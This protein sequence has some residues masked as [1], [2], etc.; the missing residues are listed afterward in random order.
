MTNRVKAFL[1]AVVII[2]TVSAP[3]FPS[4]A[5]DTTEPLPFPGENNCDLPTVGEVAT[6]TR[7]QAK[8]WDDSLNAEYRDAI[9]RLEPE[10][11]PLLMKAQQLWVRYRDANC[12]V[13]FSHGGTVSGYLGQKC[14]LEMTEARSRELHWLSS[15]DDN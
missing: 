6:C 3:I 12:A 9:K 2:A 10:R 1:G 7:D 15:E 11:R 13:G 4:A 14:I 8:S 5:Q